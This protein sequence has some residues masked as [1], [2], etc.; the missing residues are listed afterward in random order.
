M[1][2]KLIAQ[3]ADGIHR[4]SMELGGS[5]PFVVFRTPPGQGRR[6]R[7]ARS[8]ATSVRR[9]RRQALHRARVGGRGVRAPGAERVKV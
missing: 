5:A 3:A 8:S 4:V 6:W 1:G 7:H 2:R 9:A